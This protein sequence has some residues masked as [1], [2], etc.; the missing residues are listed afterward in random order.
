[1][2][3]DAYRVA[4]GVVI[5]PGDIVVTAV[6]S[7]GPGG[8]HVNKVASTAVLRYNPAEARGL[9]PQARELVLPALAA[10]LTGD[11]DLV[12]RSSRFRVWQRNRRETVRKLAMILQAAVRPRKKRVPTRPTR[13][14][15]RNRL[16]GKRRRSQKKCGR[17][18]EGWDME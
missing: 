5:L 13:A 18:P 2:A 7:S 16:A 10:R 15:N 8:Q 9:S 1:M 4:P 17:R 14:A 6:R 11:G 3:E 12:I